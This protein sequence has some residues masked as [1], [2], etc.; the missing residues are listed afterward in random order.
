MWRE[1]T[2]TAVVGAMVRSDPSPTSVIDVAPLAGWLEQD[3]RDFLRVATDFRREMVGAYAAQGTPI[4]QGP[5]TV[6]GHPAIWFY[7][8]GSADGLALSNA[9]AHV[10]SFTSRS[11]GFSS[12]PRRQTSRPWSMTSAPSLR[13][14]AGPDTRHLVRPFRAVMLRTVAPENGMQA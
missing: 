9:L 14:H 13:P 10:R 12:W 7:H 1:R 8:A 3:P 11:W 4:Q 6:R 2:R 5:G